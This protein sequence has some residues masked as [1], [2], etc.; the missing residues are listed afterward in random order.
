V[1][2]K[3]ELGTPPQIIV[4]EEHQ[5]LRTIQRFATNMRRYGSM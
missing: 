1:Q 4:E 3:L 2:A 5:P